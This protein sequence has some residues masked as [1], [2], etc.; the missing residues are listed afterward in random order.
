MTLAT[1]KVRHEVNVFL[2]RIGNLPAIQGTV[3]CVCGSNRTDSE[4]EKYAIK[5][6]AKRKNIPNSYLL[7]PVARITKSEFLKGQP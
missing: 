2:D 5:K 1:Q 4:I 7:D 3:T 6:F